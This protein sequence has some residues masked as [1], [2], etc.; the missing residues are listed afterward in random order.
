MH[1]A[2]VAQDLSAGI[3]LASRLMTTQVTRQSRGSRWSSLV[4]TLSISLAGGVRHRSREWVLQ[5]ARARQ[6]IAALVRI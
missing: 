2:H 6:R 1:L 4:C 5:K 3:Q